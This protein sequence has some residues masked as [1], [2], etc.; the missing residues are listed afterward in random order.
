MENINIA[1]SGKI[2][3]GEY[4]QVKISGSGRVL[5]NIR[6]T[7]LRSA[8]SAHVE[9]DVECAGQIKCAGSFR[10]DGR[11]QADELHVSG[12]CTLGS[13]VRAR[14]FKAAGSF[15]AGGRM[16]TEQLSGAGRFTVD[17]DI[18]GD[19]VKLSGSVKVNGLLN[20]E[21]LHSRV[22]GDCR[23]GSIGG[24]EILVERGDEKNGFFGLFRKN[25]TGTLSVSTIEGDSV[26]LQ[27]T[28]ADVVRGREVV[29]S[30][31]CKIGCVEYSV[32]LKVEDDGQ[33]GERRQV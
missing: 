15:S 14:V 25:G 17:G 27:N 30:S 5:G 10:C 12:S 31:G 24:G 3:G 20:A 11:V 16:C 4:A 23:I 26:T 1:G 21:R 9:G 18:E 19:E 2:S 32:S 7:D 22:G 13:E 33:V 6:C 29:I 8:G 28:E